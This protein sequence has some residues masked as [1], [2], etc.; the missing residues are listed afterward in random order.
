M[1]RL[2]NPFIVALLFLVLF[3]GGTQLSLAGPSSPISV[4]TSIP[5][6]NPDGE[7]SLIEAIVNANDDAA[8]HADC[9]AGSGADAIE[10]AAA[11]TY[12]LT[13]VYSG[14]NGLPAITSDIT[15]NGHGATI[16]RSITPDTPN[17]RLFEVVVTGTLTLDTVILSNGLL[18]ETTVAGGAGGAILNAGTVTLTQSTVT[19]SEAIWGG[20]ILNNGSEARL[21]LTESTIRGNR[22]DQNGGGIYNSDGTLILNASTIENN[23][24]VMTYGGGIFNDAGTVTIT[25]STIQNNAAVYGG[26]GLANS[27]SV[28]TGSAT[29]TVTA[30]QVL[31]NTS[32]GPGAGILNTSGST[33][34]AALTVNT[35]TVHGNTVLGTDPLSGFGGGIA[36]MFYDTSTSSSS[37]ATLNQSTVSGNRAVNGGGIA[38]VFDQPLDGR[39]LRVTLN[40]STVSGNVSAGSGTQAGNGGGLFNTNGELLLANSTVSGNAATGTGYMSGMGGGIAS[41]GYSSPATVRLINSTISGNS[42]VAAGGGLANVRVGA[43]ATTTFNNTLVAGNGTNCYS[44]GTLTSQGHNLEDGNTCRFTQASDKVNTDPLLGLLTANGGPT[45]THA[46]LAGS[47][48]INAG[49]NATCA[50]DPVNGVDQRGVSRPQGIA[51][52]IGAYEAEVTGYTLYL[53]IAVK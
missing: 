12:T 17:F 21:S 33:H 36:N 14:S 52:D 13:N 46:L 29:L 3:Y 43:T 47:P 27:A 53:P 35:S 40:S 20:A 39:T 24:T 11:T 8:T 19:G 50:A 26:G 9:P 4:T 22:S 44:N 23:Q 42:A 18:T 1:R 51:C 38:N 34:T 31:S 30:S 16:A 32:Y 41:A 15:I 49:D 37:I 25:T 45:E 2:L 5:A 10:L 6:I 7:C 48:A 28:G